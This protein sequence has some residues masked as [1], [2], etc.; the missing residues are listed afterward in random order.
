MVAS[1]IRWGVNLT[2]RSLNSSFILHRPLYITDCF[3]CVHSAFNRTPTKANGR[4]TGV[5]RNQ[6]IAH[7]TRGQPAQHCMEPEL[8]IIS[9]YLLRNWKN[10]YS[11][12]FIFF[13][14][15]HALFYSICHWL[16]HNDRVLIKL[17][18]H[19]LWLIADYC[20]RYLLNTNV[21]CMMRC[22]NAVTEFY[23]T[24]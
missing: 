13:F 23:Y 24:F 15:K 19:G 21:Y 4:A 12:I 3:K 17:N 22:I 14:Y 6:L 18:E 11:F 1:A 8:Y 20:L 9:K 7:I 2:Y 10:L 5:E 16:N